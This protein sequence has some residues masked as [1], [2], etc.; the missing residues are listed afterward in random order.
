MDE[1][2]RSKLWDD[3]SRTKSTQIR[4]TLIIEYSPLVKVVAGR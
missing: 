1:T 2:S 3:Y 4:E